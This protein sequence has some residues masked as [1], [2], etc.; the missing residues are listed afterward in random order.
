MWFNPVIIAELHYWA[1]AAGA[2]FVVGVGYW[3]RSRRNAAAKK[4][5]VAAE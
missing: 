4:E 3:I 5:G 2:V 1:A